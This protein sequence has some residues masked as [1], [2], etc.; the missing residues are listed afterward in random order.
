MTGRRFNFSLEPLLK[1]RRR[2]EQEHQRGVAEIERQR[3]HLEDKLRRQQSAIAE[4]KRSLQT[5]LLGAVQMNDLRLHAADSIVL[6]RK[7]QGMVLELA[8]IHR[9]LEAA[10]KE[11]IE[12]ARHRRAIELLRERRFAQWKARMDKAENAALDELAV[13]AAAR[14]GISTHEAEVLS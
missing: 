12:A 10:R 14:H 7:A 2:A 11:L 13:T 3:I 5:G 8:G 9:R 1:A 6:M 4:G